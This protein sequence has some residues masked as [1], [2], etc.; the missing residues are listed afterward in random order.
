MKKVIVLFIIILL[1]LTTF[2]QDKMLSE[3][4]KQIKGKPQKITKQ[5]LN[6]N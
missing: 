2:A 6:S 1:P 3:I 5:E 4:N